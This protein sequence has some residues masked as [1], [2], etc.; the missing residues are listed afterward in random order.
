MQRAHLAL[1]IADHQRVSVDDRR[2]ALLPL[3]SWIRVK[4]VPY[5]GAPDGLGVA[6]PLGIDLRR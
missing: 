5:L 3:L 2:R 6:A 4:A 1:P